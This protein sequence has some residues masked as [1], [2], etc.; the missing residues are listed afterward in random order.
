MARYRRAR[1]TNRRASRSSRRFVRRS[2]GSSGGFAPLIYAAGYGAGRQYISNLISPLTSKIPLGDYA[3]EV[4]MLGA[5]WA[6][7][8][9]TSNPMVHKLADTAMLIEA[10]RI[11]S[12]IVGSTIKVEAATQSW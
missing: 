3:D 9:F 6:A 10:S 1:R 8:K 11:G 5:A 2:S 4:G 12:Q 7:K